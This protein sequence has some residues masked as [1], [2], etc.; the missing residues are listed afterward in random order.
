LVTRN[1]YA[2]SR[3][4]AFGWFAACNPI[5]V[6]AF[7]DRPDAEPPSVNI[8][9]C[10]ADP[11]K[12]AEGECGCGV[13]DDDFDA[14]GA[15][16]CIEG[17]PD[18]PARSEPLGACGCSNSTDADACT[19]LREAVRNLYR[20]NDRGTVITDARGGGNGTLF[21]R[22]AAPPVDLESLQINGRL[23]FDGAG[24]YVALPAGIVSSLSSATFEVW[25]TWRG[26]VYWSRIFDFGNNEGGSGQT[27][28]FLTPWNT[29]TEVVRGALS[30]AGN[31]G[32]TVVDGLDAV[33][34]GPSSGAIQHV[35]LVVDAVA[36]AMRL[37]TNGEEVDSDA[38]VDDLAAIS[39]VNNWLGRSNYSTDPPF[40][41]TLIEFRIYEQALSAELIRASFQAGPGALDD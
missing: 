32:E 30:L 36:Q 34:S 33:A 9:R 7:E 5:V 12:V 14:D 4:S 28:L 35:A 40:P 11:F 29:E 18:N 15:V 16:D 23:N 22:A 25:L 37:Y 31:P 1:L 21:H 26:G 2:L 17:C 27:Y 6:D 24:S 3:V 38:L 8:D 20:F 13:P 19:T 39:D 41:G 10:P